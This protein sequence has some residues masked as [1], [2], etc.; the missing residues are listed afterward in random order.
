MKAP[1]QL[2]RVSDDANLAEK[3]LRDER[4]DPFD[5]GEFNRMVQER[6]GASV[7]AKTRP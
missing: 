7:G 5:P 3:V 6:L 4:P 1:P 2:Q